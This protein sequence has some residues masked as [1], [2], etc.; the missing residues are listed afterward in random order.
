MEC[1]V[2]LITAPG[3]EAAAEIAEEIVRVKLAACVNIVRDVRSIY[4]WRGKTQDEEEVLMVVKTRRTLFPELM[5]RV[6]KLHRYEVPEIIALP[7]VEGSEDYLAWLKEE[8][9]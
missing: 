1:V 6:K 4:R 9:S 3:E 2:V 7:I 5:R 8:T